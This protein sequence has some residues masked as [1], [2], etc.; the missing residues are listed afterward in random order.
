M[1]RSALPAVCATLIL[2]ACMST[3]LQN[4]QPARI[5]G[6][7]PE[8]RAE[9][10]RVVSEA[11]HVTDINL[12]DNAL[13]GSSWLVIERNRVRNLENA[14]LSGRDLGHP[15]RF[16]LVVARHRC[17]LVHERDGQRYELAGVACVA[18]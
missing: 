1:S 17:V 7:T 13:R 11:L 8:S 15:E 14:P 12:A 4:E 10:Q 16:Q 3:S 18:E 6:S 9:L 5:T 2:S